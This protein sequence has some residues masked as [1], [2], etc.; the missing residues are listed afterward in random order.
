MHRVPVLLVALS[1]VAVPASVRACAIPVFRYALERW[2]LAPYEA[3][4]FHR[5]ELAAADR[6]ML[7][8]W[9]YPRANVTIRPV[10][11]AEAS[12]DATALWERHGKPT[13]LP[14]VVVRSAEPGLDV[15]PVYAGPLVDDALRPVFDSPARQKIVAALAGGDSGVLVLLESGDAAADDAAAR[16][17]DGEVARLLK[18]LRLPEPTSDGPQIRLALPLRASF[19]LLRVG[20]DD[21][22]EAAFV[23]MLVG[24]DPALAD[25]TGPILFPVFGRGRLLGSLPGDDLNEEAVFEVVNFLC[26]ACSCEAK[27]LNPGMDL[28]I[29]TNWPDTF[30]RIGNVENAPKETRPIPPKQA[31]PAARP[32][33]PFRTTAR[34]RPSGATVTV[35]SAAA[36]APDG[37]RRWLIL[38]TLGA[39]VCVVVTGAW[40]LGRRPAPASPDTE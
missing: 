20:R 5:G 4:V 31:E 16:R 1:L 32:A 33:A 7:D 12:G 25:A 37:R 36:P 10:N 34:E 38:A 13:R 35:P 21:P 15:P 18:R 3:V 29:A 22:A 30:A 9:A 6:A 26:G 24:S 28:L 14:W 2:D 11:L 17:V 27:E 40:A 19:T 8:R 23:R 39:A